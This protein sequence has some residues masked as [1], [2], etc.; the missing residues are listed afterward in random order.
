MIER[1]ASG[2]RTRGEEDLLIEVHTSPYMTTNP[3]NEPLPSAPPH[4]AT[5]ARRATGKSAEEAPTPEQSLRTM[6][7]RDYVEARNGVPLGGRGALGAMLERSLGATSLA[8]FWRHWNPAWGY[9]LWTRV[10]RPARRVLPRAL[11]VLLTFVVSG[12]LHDLAVLLVRGRT[13]GLFALSFGLM[14]VAL[15]VASALKL[16]LGRWPWVARAL[17]HV[18]YVGGCVALARALLG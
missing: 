17:V 6:S 2:A 9:Y 10:Y 5:R 4:P 18:S 11:A 1:R 7:L 8:G 16:D 12:A 15:L 3:A 13:N 14:G